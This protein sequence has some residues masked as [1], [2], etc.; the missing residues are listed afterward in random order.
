MI[1]RWAKKLSDGRTLTVEIHEVSEPK[2]LFGDEGG[3]LAT[4][5]LRYPDGAAYRYS[6]ADKIRTIIAKRGFRRPEQIGQVAPD[7]D[8]E[9][10]R[11]A[12]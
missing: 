3:P 7:L 4:A 5:E 9:P 11:R 12:I 2:P 10:P 6:T 8:D 1:E